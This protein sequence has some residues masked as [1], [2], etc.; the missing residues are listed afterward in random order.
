VALFLFRL[1][2]AI[3]DTDEWLWVVEG[4]VPS[5]YFVIDEARDPASALTLY[6]DMMGEW[7]EAVLAKS[8][9]DEVFPVDAP[10]TKEHAE[11]LHSRIEF[12]RDR[13]LPTL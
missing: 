9:L 2:T 13:V 10:A 12:M 8:S 3:N 5:A 11:M 4:D 6:C 7:A 1:Q